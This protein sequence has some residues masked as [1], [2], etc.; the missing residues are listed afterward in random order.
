[1]SRVG[2]LASGPTIE[3]GPYALTGHR[4]VVPLDHARPDGP[5]LSVFAREV[6]MREGPADL[7]W[8]VFLQGGPGFEAPRPVDGR[9]WIGRAT[10]SHRVLLLDQRGTGNSSPVDVHRPRPARELVHFRADAIVADAEAFR[11]ALA[12]G[13]RWSVLGQSYG[14]F[15]A[16]HYLCRAPEAL[17][18]VLITGGLPPLAP[19]DEVYERT[20]RLMRERS[21][22][23][24]ARFPHLAP[25]VDELARRASRGSLR[26]P[27]G[28]AVG[29]ERLQ[30]LGME[31][32]RTSG[33]E[34]LAWLFESAFADG[35]LDGPT[36]ARFL[37]SLAEAQAYDTHPFYALLHES[38]YSDGPATDWA[39]ERVR[40]AHPE[41]EWRA[42][43]PLVLTAESIHPWMFAQYADLRPFARTADELARHAPWPRLLD[44]TAMAANTV[45]VAAAV[46][47]EDLYVE[48][49][50]SLECAAALGNCRV[51]R[52]A[53]HQHDGLREDGAAILEA[54][55]RR[56]G[57]ARA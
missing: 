30:Q 27:D 38:I 49:E 43:E 6:R 56:L 32:G 55:F 28:E 40:A 1:V 10:R 15:C 2:A 9:G 36:T 19:I 12:H 14:G 17:H 46:Y 51:W 11:R 7:P 21:L 4:L 18:E 48:R 16:V 41:L 31:L 42:G 39:A 47:D 35:A 37:R 13:E 26:L 33:P 8:L 57:E 24:H 52:S 3:L 45:P 29:V 34:R 53:T 44:R 54:L 50:L 22:A 25:V 5:A 23:F 20:F